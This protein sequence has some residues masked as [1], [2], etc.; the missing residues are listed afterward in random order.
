MR[1]EGPGRSKSGIDSGSTEIGRNILLDLAERHDW[2]GIAFCGV[3][4]LLK[5]RESFFVGEIQYPF[6]SLD[7]LKIKGSNPI[8]ESLIGSKPHPM[9][10]IIAQDLFNGCGCFCHMRPL[11]EH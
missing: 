7:H 4:K 11:F 2:S 5:S 6:M 10:L 1:I 9:I 8:E 3:S